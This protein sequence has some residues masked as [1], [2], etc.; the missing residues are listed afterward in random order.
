MGLEHKKG[1]IPMDG[2]TKEQA[3]KMIKADSS[4]FTK[5]SRELKADADVALAY[6]YNCRVY[7]DKKNI[8]KKH[9][10]DRN[11]VIKAVAKRG[12]LME[13]VD[14]EFRK[15]NEIDM[16]AV[17]TCGYMQRCV[18]TAVCDDREVL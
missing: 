18:S 10:K 16:A 12:D 2:I 5:M 4:S 7:C 14:P 1:G 17:S 8:Y 15:D 11:F 6:V 3:I 9:L 13:Y